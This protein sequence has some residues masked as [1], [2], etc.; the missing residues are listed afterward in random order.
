M[1]ILKNRKSYIQ[2][3]YLYILTQYVE[4]KSNTSCEYH[5]SETKPETQSFSC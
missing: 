4:N 5:T 1:Y 2:I 3:I